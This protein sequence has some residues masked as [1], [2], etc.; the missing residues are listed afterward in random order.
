MSQ[1]VLL[2]RMLVLRWG[3]GGPGGGAAWLVSSGFHDIGAER[4]LGWAGHGTQLYQEG[5]TA[6]YSC[7]EPSG[8]GTL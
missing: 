1:K 4:R 5:A 2:L 8:P 6:S 7:S 3:E